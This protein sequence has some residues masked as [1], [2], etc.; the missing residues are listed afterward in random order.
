MPRTPLLLFCSAVACFAQAPLDPFDQ[1][2]RSYQDAQMRRNF[3]EAVARRDDA[4]ALL[5]KVPLDSPV[6]LNRTQSV[7]QMYQSAGHPAQARKVLQEALARAESLGESSQVRIQLLDILAGYWHQEGN[8]LKALSYREKVV[9]VV[10]AAPPGATTSTNL[11]ANVASFVFQSGP[12][13]VYSAGRSVNNNFFHYQQLADLYHQLGR[14]EAEAKVLAKMRSL[15]QSDPGALAGSYQREGDLDKAIALY[16][17]QIQQAAANPKAQP[18]EIAGPLQAI[19]GI[20]QGQERWQEAAAAI[21]QAVTRLESSG[22]PNASQQT[23]GMRLNQAHL[24]QQAGQTHAADQ[25]YQTLLA[26][27][28]SDRD[29]MRQPALF[30]Y[31]N[32]L[33]ETDRFDQAQEL[34]KN[35]LTSQTEPSQQANLYDGLSQIAR[36]AGHEELANEYQQK[37]LEKRRGTERR[38]PGVEQGPL[39]GPDLQK[40]QTAVSQGNLDQGTDLALR[41]IAAASSARDGDQVIWTVQQIASA[42]VTAKAPDKGEQLY[43]ALLSQL[44]T[45]SAGHAMPLG[46][47]LE[48]YTRFLITQK[49]RWGDVPA[50]I[51]RCREQMIATHGVET[52]SLEQV[53]RLKIEFARAMGAPADAMRSADDLLALEESLSGSASMPYMNAAQS[54]ANDYEASGNPDRAMALHRKIVAIADLAL[55][56]NDVLRAQVR[57][58]AAF[59]MVRLRQFETA[60]ALANE[61][62]AIGEKLK[63]PQAKQI[64]SQV[65]QVRGMKEAQA[66]RSHWFEKKT[67]SQ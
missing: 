10:E 4:E 15:M 31:A 54:V 48:T 32:F 14:P 58:N 12:N 3:P 18:W 59:T 45:W 63:P 23:F 6:F 30:A 46:Q 28:A 26:G 8:L 43:R 49:D 64:L 1:I 62:V 50:A 25:L 53:M 27:V 36:R 56:A 13:R 67:G 60:D 51:E 55:P 40:A 37:A 20:Y 61:A 65:Q 41:A 44:S 22:G 57:V 33:T 5:S 19:A 47:A 2:M 24:L 66:Q 42:L 11:R 7:S 16:Q 39:V 17:Q 52:S 34:F 9:A 35:S 38:P 29:G 21:D